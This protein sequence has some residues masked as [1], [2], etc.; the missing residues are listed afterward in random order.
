MPMVKKDIKCTNMESDATLNWVHDSQIRLINELMDTFNS[1][2]N[3]NQKNGHVGTKEMGDHFESAVEDVIKK[4]ISNRR[5]KLNLSLDK[6][7]VRDKNGR[8]YQ[9]DV[10]IKQKSPNEDNVLALIEVKSFADKS[11]FRV[12]KNNLE[13]CGLSQKGFYVGIAGT[14]KEVLNGEDQNQY[15]KIFFLSQ[16]KSANVSKKIRMKGLEP[17]PNSLLH[18][19]EALESIIL[20]STN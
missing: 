6:G 11:G 7:F 2:I 17:Y 8:S 4:F 3:S 15:P 9:I 16:S 18:F 20:N 5:N 13:A 10:I 12:F 19:L 14:M 1:N